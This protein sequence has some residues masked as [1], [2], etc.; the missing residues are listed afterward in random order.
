MESSQGRAGGSL[1][2]FDYNYC[3][4]KYITFSSFK[5]VFLE[6]NTVHSWLTGLII[7][8][9]GKEGERQINLYQLF[10][11]SFYRKIYKEFFSLFQAA[12]EDFINYLNILINGDEKQK[13][14]QSFEILDSNRKGFLEFKDIENMIHGVCLLWNHLTGTKG[15]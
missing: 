12:F 4:Q 13:I 14:R 10:K 9:I 3:I 1:Q 6:W 7:L 11:Q 8:S 5:Q 15:E 2:V